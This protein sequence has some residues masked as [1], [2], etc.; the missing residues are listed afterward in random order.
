MPCHVITSSCIHINIFHTKTG[1]SYKNSNKI[2][3]PFIASTTCA[4][5]SRHFRRHFLTPFPLPSSPFFF[6]SSFF[7]FGKFSFFR[8]F[9]SINP[10]TF[11]ASKNFLQ[12]KKK[13]VGDFLSIVIHAI[14]NYEKISTCVKTKQNKTKQIK[15]NQNKTKQNK[16]SS[17]DGI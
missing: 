4:T 5:S 9:F 1:N 17:N 2:A 11:Y 16:T 7:H 15:S 8:F 12:L 6:S 13:S 3:V 14:L 10:I